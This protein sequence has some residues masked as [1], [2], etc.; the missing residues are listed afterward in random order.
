[1]V[2]KKLGLN[3]IFT[4]FLLV[5]LLGTADQLYQLNKINRLNQ[6]I[7]HGELVKDADY[8]YLNNFSIAYSEAQKNDYKH[9]IRAYGK[10]LE[11]A[12]SSTDEANIEYNIAN[13]LFLSGLNQK[14]NDDGSFSEEALYA[15][16]QAK[17]AY[18]QSLRIKPEQR[19]AKFNL[20]L[21]DLMM[22]T[23]LKQA[24][25]EKPAMELSNLPVGLP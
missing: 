11:N 18:E 23:H 15:Y 19:A 2:K 1:M 16:I 10:L 7:A 14:M 20:S 22:L 25:Q 24:P 8:P 12:P 4:I 3:V 5:G 13:S 21:L 6:M 9:A 17:I